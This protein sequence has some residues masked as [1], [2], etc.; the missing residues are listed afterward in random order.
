M[1]RRKIKLKMVFYL[2]ILILIEIQ[3]FFIVAT[4]KSTRARQSSLPKIIE[5]PD[6]SPVR[7]FRQIVMIEQCPLVWPAFGIKNKIFEGLIPFFLS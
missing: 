7:R 2:K 3:F 4:R 5:T 6:T 1:K